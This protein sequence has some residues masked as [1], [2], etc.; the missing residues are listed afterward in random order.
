M[1]PTRR[2]FLLLA[3]GA[4]AGSAISRIAWAQ[5]YPARPVRIIVGYPSGGSNDI[6]ARLIAQWLSERMGQQFVIE[7]RPG[8]G[9]NIA[10]EAVVR[11]DPDGYTLLMV[12]AANMSN[13]ALYDRLNYNIIRDIAPVAG[14]MRVPLVMEV[15]PSIPAKTVPEF[16]A[17]AKANPGK[18]NFASGGIGTSIHLSGELFK[19]MT[20]IDMQHVPYRGNGPALT[21]LLGGQVQIMFDTMPAAIGYVRAGQLRALAVTTAM[22]SEALP[23]VPTVGEYVPGYEASSLY[24][25]AAPGNTPADIVDKLNR[26][27]NA[28][29]ADLA[30]KTRL[31]DLGGIVLPG[32][33]ADFGK[34]IAVETDKWAKVIRTGNIKPQ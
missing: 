34:L 21:D 29:L 3:A 18:I 1:K 23:D 27:I 7:N 31:A 9:S 5:A 25:V 11:A 30:M 12:S 15:N 8:A 10:T 2:Q 17:Y 26:E 22:R 16:I 28:A 33:P 6:L 4:G 13:A 32:S 24:G 20:G 14:V 19:M